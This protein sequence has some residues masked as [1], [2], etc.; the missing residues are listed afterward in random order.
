MGDAGL[1]KPRY[2]KGELVRDPWPKL[3]PDCKGEPLRVIRGGDRCPFTC[4]V[5]AQHRDAVSNH[6]W[7]SCYVI[8]CELCKGTGTVILR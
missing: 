4:H 1:T 7:D 5:M 2:E 8:R 6:H 3:C